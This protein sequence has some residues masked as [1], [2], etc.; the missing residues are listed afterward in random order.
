[1]QHSNTPSSSRDSQY[2]L[3]HCEKSHLDHYP[4]ISAQ[5]RKRHK[6]KVSLDAIYKQTFILTDL[7]TDDPQP[8]DRL[9]RGDWSIAQLKKE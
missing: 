8:H 9:V 4:L 3:G 1:M 2:H 7:L 6:N 5:L